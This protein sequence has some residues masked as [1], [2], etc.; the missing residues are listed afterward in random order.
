VALDWR[1]APTPWDK[2]TCFRRYIEGDPIG[3]RA[4][5]KLAGRPF[6]A[7]QLW[8]TQDKARGHAW[9]EE[10]RK[11]HDNLR[12][13]T[14]EKTLEK[15][16]EQIADKHAEI[17]VDHFEA[18]KKYRNLALMNA[19]FQTILV[20]QKISL[21]QTAR[22]EDK[23]DAAQQAAIA[24]LS[25]SKEMSLW[26]GVLDR[27]IAREREA[28]DVAQRS[29]NIALKTVSSAG[30]EVTNVSEKVMRE[31]LEAEGYQIIAPEGAQ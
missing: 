31:Y 17:L 30:F 1:D 27:A 11:W 22:E 12:T 21:Y 28:L 24:L 9:P 3:Y 7:L 5:A 6:G 19:E 8:T 25:M 20:N 2:E 29:V 14:T 26:M 23:L 13:K 10:R 18:V 15:A 4:L 16:S